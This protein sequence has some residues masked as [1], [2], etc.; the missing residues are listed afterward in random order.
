MW[1][2][3]QIFVHG[4]EYCGIWRYSIPCIKIETKAMSIYWE[5]FAQKSITFYAANICSRPS[6]A[7]ENTHSSSYGP[8][9]CLDTRWYFSRKC[10]RVMKIQCSPEWALFPE[11][12]DPTFTKVL[13]PVRWPWKIG[14]TLKIHYIL[15][16]IER[17]DVVR[18]QSLQWQPTWPSRYFVILA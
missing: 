16:L 14:L 10:E 12:M 1:I 5:L 7:L 9:A 2:F 18:M 6:K 17:E 15:P 13:L 4:I 11:N 8:L 3:I